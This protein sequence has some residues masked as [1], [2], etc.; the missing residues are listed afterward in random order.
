M[1]D[2]E[3]FAEIDKVA[4]PTHKELITLIAKTPHGV[5]R[6]DFEVKL[7]DEVKERFGLNDDISIIIESK[8]DESKCQYYYKHAKIEAD[9]FYLRPDNYHPVSTVRILQECIAQDTHRP[10]IKPIESGEIQ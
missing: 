2:Q 3:F 10:D 4:V 9:C 7:D 8:P 1:T 6:I 5:S